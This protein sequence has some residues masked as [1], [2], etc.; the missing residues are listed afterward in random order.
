MSVSLQDLK[1]KSLVIFRS[2]F[3]SQMNPVERIA[4][5]Q[6]C[7]ERQYKAGEYI[8]YQGDPGTGMYIIENGVVELVVE[9]EGME[10]ADKPRYRLEA[11]ESFGALS[12]GYEMRRMSSARCVTDCTLYGFFKPDLET[13]CRRFPKVG[14]K[15]LSILNMIALRQ[16]Q[17]T[18]NSLMK[19]T[20][21]SQALALQF[22]T[23]YSGGIAEK[24]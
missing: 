11:P 17:I 3:L 7:N 19:H 24:G 21:E 20:G 23:Y 2:R 10:D 6:L 14:I 13:L 22:E 4:F 9:A 15:F 8:Y 12:V 18:V 5:L 16:L 1:F